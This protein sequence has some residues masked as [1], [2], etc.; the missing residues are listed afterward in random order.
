MA[1]GIYRGALFTGRGKRG[2]ADLLG[3]DDL[4]GALKHMTQDV[5]GE[6]LRAAVDAGAEITRD[7]ASQLAPRSEDGSHG[8]EP[9]FLSENIVKER[10]YTRT[11]DTA[12]THV[13]MTKEAWYGQLQ[14]TG[15]IYAPAQPFERPALDSTKNDV[16][17]EIAEHLRARIHGGIS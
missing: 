4:I 16:I 11:Q 14:E 7:V 9:G 12:V 15:T 3:V 5:Q 13:G 1:A 10:Q 17:D 6:H 2:T 8:R